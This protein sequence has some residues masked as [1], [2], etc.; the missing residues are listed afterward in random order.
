MID[1]LEEAK[2]LIKSVQTELEGSPD[3]ENIGRFKRLIEACEV[4]EERYKEYCEGCDDDLG[5]KSGETYKEGI[6]MEFYI[7]SSDWHEISLALREL[8]K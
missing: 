1:K 4:I 2:E 5:L 6:H 7:E 3:Y 8:T